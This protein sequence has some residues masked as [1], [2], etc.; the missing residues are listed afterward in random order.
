VRGR[1]GRVP[2]RDQGERSTYLAATSDLVACR[3][4]EIVGR[5][6]PWLGLRMLTVIAVV[7][8]LATRI[9]AR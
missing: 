7:G 8:A 2:V 3:T 9:S 5:E 6:G 1:D 4:R